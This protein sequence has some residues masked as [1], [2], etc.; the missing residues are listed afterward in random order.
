MI[1]HLSAPDRMVAALALMT[2]ACERELSPI[3]HGKFSFICSVLD[4][5]QSPLGAIEYGALRR[6]PADLAIVDAANSSGTPRKGRREQAVVEAPLAS[7][8][9]LRASCRR[10]IA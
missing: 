9:I 5:E 8:A 6:H 2:G 3:Q 1:K 10:G 4:N 7:R